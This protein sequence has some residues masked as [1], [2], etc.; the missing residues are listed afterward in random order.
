MIDEDIKK[1]FDALKE[2]SYVMIYNDKLANK[3]KQFLDYVEY[4]Y[5][6]NKDRS[7]NCPERNRFEHHSIEVE[8]T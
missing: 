6:L 5:Y 2:H 8:T 4:S 1:V 3:F 7:D